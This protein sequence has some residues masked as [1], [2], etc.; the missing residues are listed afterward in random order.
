M[1]QTNIPK[2]MDYYWPLVHHE[3]FPEDAD[4]IQLIKQKYGND[5]VNTLLSFKERYEKTKA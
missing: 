3:S 2:F 5:A 4:Y 1:K